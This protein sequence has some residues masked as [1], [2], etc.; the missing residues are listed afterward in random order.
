MTQIESLS[1]EDKIATRL[2]HYKHAYTEHSCFHYTTCTLKR[3]LGGFSAGEYFHCISVTPQC[4][5]LELRKGTGLGYWGP[6]IRILIPK[7]VILEANGIDP[8]D[9]EMVKKI[10]TS[11]PTD[12]Y[13]DSETVKL[14]NVAE[15]YFT[16]EG[17]EAKSKSIKITNITVKKTVKPF[18]EEGDRFLSISITSNPVEFE[19]VDQ[20]GNSICVWLSTIQEAENRVSIGETSIKH[21]PIDSQFEE[22][23]DNVPELKQSMTE[24][25]IYDHMA[26]MKKYNTLLEKTNALLEEKIARLEGK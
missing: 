9:P 23:P 16:W 10:M 3:D 19:M 14:S 22:K 4:R 18:W 26:L 24:H 15:E 11:Y 2:F 8:E 17:L 25:M 20:K 1:I 21:T 12:L 7:D 13:K 5:F 6:N